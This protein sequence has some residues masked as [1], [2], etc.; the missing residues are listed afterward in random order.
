MK[1]STVEQPLASFLRSRQRMSMRSAHPTKAIH[2]ISVALV[3]AAL[4]A[5]TGCGGPNQADLDSLVGGSGDTSPTTAPT[6][7]P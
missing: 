4:L 2:H 1:R 3:V 6:T 7:S 5:L